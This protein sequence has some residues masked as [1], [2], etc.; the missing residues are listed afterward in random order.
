MSK[1]IY[2]IR[3]AEPE[4]IDGK[5]G[6]LSDLGRT[7]AVSLA[8]QLQKA[9]VCDST[10]VIL[11]AEAERCRQ[12]ATIMAERLSI[13]STSAPLRFKHA[14]RLQAKEIQSK[15]S[16]Y[17]ADYARLGIEAPS[18]FVRRLLSI[19]DKQYEEQ[20]L[21]VANEVNIRVTLQ[22]LAG[23]AYNAPVSHA[24]CYRILLDGAEPA[25]VERVR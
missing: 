11:H 22:I 14:S 8:C 10:A 5:K 12:T 4:I 6:P 25:D 19:A 21:I 17:L 15:Y 23:T 1:S 3:H 7:Q 9:G 24:A 16:S 2:L 18:I 13:R 20:V